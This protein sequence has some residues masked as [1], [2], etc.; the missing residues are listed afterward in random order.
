MLESKTPYEAWNDRQSI[1]THLH[2]FGTHCVAYKEKAKKLDDHGIK[3][4]LLGYEASNQ[5][6]LWDIKRRCTM[7]AV[8]VSFDEAKPIEIK[9]DDGHNDDLDYATLNFNRPGRNNES[10]TT[11]QVIESSNDT[12]NVTW[13]GQQSPPASDSIINAE[14]EH[15]LNPEE[16]TDNVEEDV[17]PRRSIRTRNEQS[18][19]RIQNPWNRRL[20]GED[21]MD[22]GSTRHI[23]L[24]SGNPIK[25][26]GFAAHIR[27]TKSTNTYTI[28][29]N[30]SDV[31]LH[32]DKY[33]FLEA[34]RVE[35]NHHKDKKTWTT[36][37]PDPGTK[38]IDG[39]WVYAIKEDAE[40]N[41]VRWKARWVAKGFLQ[42]YDVDFFETYS[43]VVKTM[44]WQLILAL[45]AK[46]DY[47]AHHVDIVTAFLESDLKERVF[48]RQP[49]GFE[50]KG[51][52]NLACLLLKALYG[53]KQSPR[54]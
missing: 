12:E 6:V 40:G 4:R 29:N 47:E 38:V 43:G 21:N 11:Q 50:E 23:R 41:I 22:T 33:K 46:Y 37:L 35:V 14:E 39:R 26:R 18:Y 27:K 16:D 49:I 52:A 30:F 7:R 31:L 53:L 13:G 36:M 15:H 25:A 28:P 34:M 20:G 2:P 44:I 51:D 3:C 1:L 8:H 32:P 17:P 54:A 10:E 42:K 48:V 24:D 5:Y 19:A 45:V 9:E